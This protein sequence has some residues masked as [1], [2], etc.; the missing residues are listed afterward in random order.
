MHLGGQGEGIEP[1]RIL[2]PFLEIA[3]TLKERNGF[4][5]HPDTLTIWGC[6]DNTDSSRESAN[7]KPAAGSEAAR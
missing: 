5:G 1:E 6:A 3:R 2:N 4:G 7:K